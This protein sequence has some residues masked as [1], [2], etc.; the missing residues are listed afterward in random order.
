MVCLVHGL[1]VSH[2]YFVPLWRLLPGAQ[3]PDLDGDD[4]ESLGASLERAVAPAS[5]LVANSLGSQLALELAVGRPDLV[6]ALVLVGPTGDPERNRFATQAARLAACAVVESPRLVPLVARDYARWGV[7][8]LVRAARSMLARPVD[9]LLA[10]VAAPVTVVRGAHDPI[11]SRRWA[12]RIASDV[13]AGRFVPVPGAAHAVHWSHPV[14]VA[15][16]VE[17][18]EDGLR[19]RFRGLDHRDVVGS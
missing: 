3:C 12:E 8:R 16:L 19:E 2:R 13:P 18:V 11:C 1:G 15:R 9:G 10:R 4:V 5:V 17:E 6:A 7:P 14:V